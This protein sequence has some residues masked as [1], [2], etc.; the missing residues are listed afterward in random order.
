[1][2]LSPEVKE[3]PAVSLPLYQGRTGGEPPLGRFHCPES[4][5]A[6]GRVHAFYRGALDRRDVVEINAHSGERAGVSV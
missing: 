5:E 1:M 6:P 3:F 4:A 2:L